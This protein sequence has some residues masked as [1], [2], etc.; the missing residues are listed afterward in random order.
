MP[1]QERRRS[2][3]PTIH[4]TRG[5][6]TA[7]SA[8][9]TRHGRPAQLGPADLP[10]KNFDLLS[11][12]EQLDV[13]AWPWRDPG[14][15]QMPAPVRTGRR[16]RTT[17]PFKN[18]KRR[19]RGSWHLQARVSRSRPPAVGRRRG[20][21]RTRDLDKSGDPRSMIATPAWPDDG[22]KLPTAQS[23]E[24][25]WGDGKGDGA[26]VGSVGTACLISFTT[27]FTR[28]AQRGTWSVLAG[29]S[30]A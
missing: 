14:A 20:C 29:I 11:Q 28:C 19:D 21:S 4:P 3:D 18:P 13:L 23:T 10:A 16:P 7:G 26:V 25:S 8:P 15:R 17:A 9:H 5:G 1:T 30:Y 27:W 24:R 2:H 22:I 6:A 12:H